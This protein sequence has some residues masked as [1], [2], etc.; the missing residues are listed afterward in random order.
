MVL[1]GWGRYNG[2]SSCPE[3]M[4]PNPG[5]CPHRGYPARWRSAS[6]QYAEMRTATFYAESTDGLRWT[7]PSLGLVSWNGSTDNNIV[8]DA[9]TCD[10]NRGVYLDS[11]DTN[12]SRRFKLFGSVNTTGDAVYCSWSTRALSVAVSPDGIHWSDWTNVSVM[13]VA[14]DTANSV[15]YDESL[16]RYLAFTRRHCDTEYATLPFC[17]GKVKEWGMRREV[18]SDAVDFLST[19]NWSYALEVAHGEAGGTYDM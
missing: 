15:V 18:R 1:V 17:R 2:L 10:G 6:T 7:K 16:Q 4:Y 3:H 14:A 8:V 11:H 5:M 19:T 12:A 13:N 9:G